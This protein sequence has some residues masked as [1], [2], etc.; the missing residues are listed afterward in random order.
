MLRAH[1]VRTSARGD[2]RETIAIERKQGREEG[3]K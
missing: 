3:T 1:S 2:R